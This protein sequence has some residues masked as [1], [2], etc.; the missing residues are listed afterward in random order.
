MTGNTVNINSLTTDNLNFNKGT[1]RGKVLLDR[2][3]QKFGAGRSI[4][5]DK[6][7]R[8]I[9]G[10]KSVGSAIAA[11]IDK[12]RIIETTGD[13]LVAVRRSD[14]D[15]SSALGREMALADN[16]TSKANF[17]LNYDNIMQAVQDVQ[18]DAEA[19]TIKDIGSLVDKAKEE[20]LTKEEK[21]EVEAKKFIFKGYSIDMTD[22]EYNE[23][24]C[25]I[26]EYYDEMGVVVGFIANLLNI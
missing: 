7:N 22:E 23:L 25:L 18:L 2:S 24:T 12:V 8:I 3:F 10:N 17:S 19:W 9:A 13:E 11:G 21:R 1:L 26:E 6:N 15:L 16:A 5:L 14:I 20:K 4:L